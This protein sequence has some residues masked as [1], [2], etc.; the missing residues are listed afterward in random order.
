MNRLPNPED[1]IHFINVTL[2]RLELEVQQLRA[3]QSKLRR[4]LNELNATTSCFPPETLASIFA[5]Y[6]GSSNTLKGPDS[7]HPLFL[8]SVCS[9]WRQ[10]V[11]STPDLWTVLALG[12]PQDE[13]YGYEYMLPVMET[14]FQ[15]AGALP[16]AVKI[17]IPE[18]AR[19]GPSNTKVGHRSYIPAAEIFNFIFTKHPLKLGRLVIGNIPPRW[20]SLLCRGPASSFPSFPNLKEI[21]LSYPRSSAGPVLRLFQSSSAPHLSRVSLLGYEPTELPWKQITHL[22]VEGM[23]IVHC[24]N[25]L[26]R[27]LNL[28]EYQCRKPSGGTLNTRSGDSL[29]QQEVERPSLKRLTW[30]FGLVGMDTVLLTYA[31]FPSLQYLD[32]RRH[33]TYDRRKV[34]LPMYRQLLT[35]FVSRLGSLTVFITSLRC[36]TGDELY[37]ALPSTVQEL[38]LTD[39]VH[40]RDRENVLSLLR[41]LVIPDD[42]MQATFLP[43]LKL[44]AFPDGDFLSGNPLTG[45]LLRML[46]SRRDGPAD[47]WETH[48]RLE[49]LSLPCSQRSLYGTTFIPSAFSS[50]QEPEWKGY[51]VMEL[52]RLVVG[53]L[54]VELVLPDGF[55]TKWD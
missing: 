26:A 25:M 2:R 17:S 12:M 44:L 22:E 47:K 36:W 24:L 7:Y 4:R 35:G 39:A 5:A 50:F 8:G 15:R 21:S 48:T 19:F 41:H 38:H 52:R 45:I 32:Y 30:E 51:Q 34:S 10:V 31:R 37:A 23:S 53:G 49:C 28:V 6:S 13:M 43:H 46:Q 20:W 33:F 29:M 42:D 16:I 9:Q 40:H 3:V 54:G 1:E 14:Y 11:N 27:C 55:I 18:K